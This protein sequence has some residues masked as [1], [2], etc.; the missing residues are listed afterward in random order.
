MRFEAESGIPEIHRSDFISSGDSSMSR[1]GDE[2]GRIDRCPVQSQFWVVLNRTLPAGVGNEGIGTNLHVAHECASVP[3]A[4]I[5]VT[6]AIYVI[7]VVMNYLVPSQVF[8]IVP[9]CRLRCH[10]LL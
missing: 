1:F 4:G 5:L 6:V 8:E 3:Y 2:R 10:G 9:N 7:G